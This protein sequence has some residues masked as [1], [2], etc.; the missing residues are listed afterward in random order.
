[1]AIAAEPIVSILLGPQWT[2]CVP[3]VQLLC[4]ASLS[5]FAASLSYPVFVSAGHVR[6]ALISSLISIPPSVVVIVIASFFGTTAVAASA[7]LT[8]PFQVAVVLAFIRKRLNISLSELSGALVKSGVV[9]VSSAAAA[10]LAMVAGQRVFSFAV[11]Q[12]L[13]AGTAAFVGWCVGVLVTQHP[14]LTQLRLAGKD[15][16]GWLRQTKE[17]RLAVGRFPFRNRM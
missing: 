15:V 10:G 11:L 12:L 2:G 6:D 17:K 13:L 7:L 1:M 4:I 5:M 8:L 14:L 16:L 9:S 3:L